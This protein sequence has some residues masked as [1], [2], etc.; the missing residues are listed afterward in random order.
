MIQIRQDV[1]ESNSSSTHS[2]CIASKSEYDAWCDYELYL[3][4]YWNT[5]DELKDKKFIT[6]DEVI[7][8]LGDSEHCKYNEE[9]L[10]ELKDD[11]FDKVA[12]QNDVY[13]CDNW[14]DDEGLEV[15][16]NKY[17]TKN[18]DEIVVICKYGCDY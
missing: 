12:Y 8:I 18:G 14:F 10:R 16:E 5:P 1:F 9:K 17:T 3:N 4:E 2:I 7:A 13:T 15:D 11:E 6:K